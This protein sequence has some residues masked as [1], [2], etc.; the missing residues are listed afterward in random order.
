M[1]RRELFKGFTGSLAA[2]GLSAET[3]TIDAIDLPPK[4][5]ATLVV[6]RAKGRLSKQNVEDIRAQWEHLTKDTDWAHVKVAILD[7]SM[8]LEVHT[9]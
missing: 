7:D 2:A 9:T 8:E 3:M 5:K 6:L 1:T 4:P